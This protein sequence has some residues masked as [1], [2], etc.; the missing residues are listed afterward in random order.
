[1]G[2]KKKKDARGNVGDDYHGKKKNLLLT[3]PLEKGRVSFAGEQKTAKSPA[4]LRKKKTEEEEKQFAG[5]VV[6][7]EVSGPK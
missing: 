5:G 6:G 3:A 2:G 4:S 7:K 1:M